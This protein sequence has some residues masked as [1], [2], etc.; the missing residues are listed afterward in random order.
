MDEPTKISEIFS[1]E[2]RIRDWKASAAHL[3][4]TRNQSALH[5]YYQCHG[6]YLAMWKQYHSRK[7]IMATVPVPVVPKRL[8]VVVKDREVRIIET[9]EPLCEELPLPV[10]KQYPPDQAVFGPEVDFP[11][12]GSYQAA[13]L[14]AG[15]VKMTTLPP[16]VVRTHEG[17]DYRLTQFRG[18][19]PVLIWVPVEAQ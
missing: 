6:N 12:P 1:L 2:A 5:N 9:D 16:G 19:A 8:E 7:D 4:E 3:A 18:L 10:E 14:V 17:R 15:E 11:V 13:A